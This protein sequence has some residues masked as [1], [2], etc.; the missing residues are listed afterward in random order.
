M[1]I[2]QSAIERKPLTYE[3]LEAKC[4]TLTAQLADKCLLVEQL[5]QALNGMRGHVFGLNGQ[6]EIANRL[7]VGEK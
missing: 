5:R 1:E 4:E 6:F 3:E 2:E 7:L